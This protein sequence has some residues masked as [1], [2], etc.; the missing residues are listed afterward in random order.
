MHP[1]GWRRAPH[2]VVALALTLLANFYL[3]ETPLGW[4]L[5]LLGVGFF[6]Y[7]PPGHAP[8]APCADAGSN[9]A[10]HRGDE[11]SRATC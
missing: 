4:A 5:A 2:L 11:R 6:I 10:S 7:G 1:R 8:P 9:R 3:G